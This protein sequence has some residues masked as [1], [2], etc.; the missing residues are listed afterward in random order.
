MN[1]KTLV[2]TAVFQLRAE[3]KSEFTT[4]DICNLA[5]QIDPNRHRRSILG[6][7]PGLVVG[8]RHPVYTQADQFL[9]HVRRGVYRMY[10]PPEKEVSKRR[11]RR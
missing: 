6:T 8:R 5:L 7:L 9:E 10:Q 3:G 11:N 4:A 2:Q 1:L